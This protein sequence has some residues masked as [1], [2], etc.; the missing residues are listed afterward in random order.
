MVPVGN[1]DHSMQTRPFFMTE[2]YVAHPVNGNL[3]M[4]NLFFALWY[5]T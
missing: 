3:T 2:G 5:Q 1:L 4:N